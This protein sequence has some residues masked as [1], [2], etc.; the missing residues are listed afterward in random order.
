MILA[1]ALPGWASVEFPRFAQRLINAH[2]NPH[3]CAQSMQHHARFFAMIGWKF[4]D[5][6]KTNKK[7]MLEVF[8]P[9][10]IRRYQVAADDIRLHVLATMPTREEINDLVHKRQQ[11]ALLASVVAPWQQTILSRY[12]KHLVSI[13]D[14]YAKAGWV[15]DNRKFVA[16]TI[17]VC[18][19]CARNLLVSLP[20]HYQS[21]GQITG[22]DICRLL[23]ISPGQANGLRRFVNYLNG[24]R[25]V[26]RRLQIKTSNRKLPAGLPF[27][28]YVAIRQDIVDDGQDNPKPALLLLLALSFGLSLHR[29]VRL[30]ATCLR[31]EPGRGWV[32]RIKNND[33]PL[34]NDMYQI[35][36]DYL[37]GERVLGVFD[38]DSKNPYLFPGRG[39][40]RHLSET[41]A[42]EYYLKY[43][44]A[45]DVVTATFWTNVFRVAGADNPMIFV[46]SLGHH[47]AR[48]IQFF[49]CLAPTMMTIDDNPL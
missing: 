6:G 38:T 14:N 29:V 42:H 3:Y 39:A 4:P 44:L 18:L 26:F 43:G 8:T 19:R 41:A 37:S 45:S 20:G 31:H 25:L 10:T 23:A 40:G 21:T 15:G 35:V 13:A 9:E 46:Q 33:I 24:H 2:P 30:L 49:Q 7:E 16:K 47:P 36:E 32:F 12:Y 27:D 1:E 5:P 34:P 48:A 17:T 28:R 22:E 11:A